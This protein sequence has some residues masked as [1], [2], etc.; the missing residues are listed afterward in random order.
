MSQPWFSRETTLVSP[1]ESTSKT[2]DAAGIARDE[3]QVAQAHSVRP[4]QVRL[5]AE[6][7]SVATRVVQDGLDACSLLDQ[8][9]ERQS[10]DARAGSN[11]VGDVDHVDT[12]YLEPLRAFDDL[13]D[14]EAA[15]R[16]QF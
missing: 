12:P 16:E 11:P 10:A 8:H 15:R 3:Q 9:G 7:I 14:L 4:Q 13:I 6:Q 2:A 5:N 1:I